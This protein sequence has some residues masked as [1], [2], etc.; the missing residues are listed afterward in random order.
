MN[1]AT[2]TLEEAL[3]KNKL[4]EEENSTLKTSLQN[5]EKSFQILKEQ[6]EWFK[7]QIF[8]K[9]SERFISN[10][11]QPE[12]LGFE[13]PVDEPP[14]KKRRIDAHDRLESPRTGKDK[15]D[16]PDDLPKETIIL[17]LPEEEKIC[18]ETGEPLVKI[19]EEITRRLAFRPGS[20]FIKEFIRPKYA[21]KA[22]SESGVASA[23][24]PPTLLNRC[25]ADD[26]LLADILVKKF[27]DHLPLYRQSEM[28]ARENILISR[29]VLSKWV[30]RAGLGL[31]PLYDLMMTKILESG[32]VFVDETP[33]SMLEPG[34]GK[35]KQAYLW[36]LAGGTS[37]DPPYRIYAFYADRRHANILDLLE[38]Y[39]GVLHSDKYAGYEKL[40]NQ[41]RFIWC[42]CYSHIRRK[43]FE[44]ETGD[45]DFREW[46]LKKI[47]ELF[48]L[49]ETAWEMSPEARLQ[50]RQEK[51]L[52]IVNE[53]IEK[54]KGKL[55]EGKTLPKSKLR[56]A[57]GYFCGLIPHLKNY[58]NHPWA[59]LDNNVAERAIRPLAIGRKNWL[60]VGNEDG[61][62]AAAILFSIVQTCRALK[63]N[64]RVYL[65]DIMR[66]LMDHPANK[67]AELL[68]D[69]WAQAQT[70]PLPKAAN[71]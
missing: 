25:F 7:R 3:S 4:L 52:P 41:K 11:E 33:V 37:R 69:Q 53:L 31:K 30:V 1:L 50:L 35:A 8:G 51:E 36:T 59:R 9:K 27:G 64:P 39:G 12:L 70:T 17:D 2:C 66:R 58:I 16:L 55:L 24:L 65:E 56:E 26:S 54:I 22:S 18:K 40:A 45:P 13:C 68:P 57:I 43:F 5:L 28:F 61:G 44:S 10:E 34:A 23:E 60:F 46:V 47:Q 42:P 14:T 20:Y 38:D 67:L 71:L 15:I 32:N 62:E 49:E 21:S 63:V 48:K 6:L 19:G 29:Q